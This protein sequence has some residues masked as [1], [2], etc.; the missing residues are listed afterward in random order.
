MST[1]SATLNSLAA[2]TVVDFYRPL[3]RSSQDP[4]E[5]LRR[6]RWVT[7]VWGGLL[8][9]LAMLAR[10]WGPVLEAGLTIASVTYGALLGLFLLGR[11]AP[12][13]TPT[14]AAAGM[15]LGLAAILYVKFFTSL[16]WTWYVLVGTLITFAAGLLL[17]EILPRQAESRR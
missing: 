9:G 1:S 6:S 3:A 13:T 5:L 2:C 17:S 10:Q 12:R 15:L 8:I 16:A 11:L 4:S 14:A 7:V